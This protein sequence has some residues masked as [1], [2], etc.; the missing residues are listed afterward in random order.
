MDA[1][2]AFE[3]LKNGKRQ[4]IELEPGNTLQDALVAKY[5][6]YLFVALYRHNVDRAFATRPLYI[7]FNKNH[8]FPIH[9][10][11]NHAL[12]HGTCK[13]K[14]V[15]VLK[16]YRKIDPPFGHPAF[17]AI[18]PSQNFLPWDRI[19]R[20]YLFQHLLLSSLSDL[21]RHGRRMAPT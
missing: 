18:D 13:I 20:T 16:D 2:H 1:R 8:W 7:F 12:L 6:L 21:C 5:I 14:P 19:E 11:N 15:H 4:Y 3:P 17:E 9:R 10:Y